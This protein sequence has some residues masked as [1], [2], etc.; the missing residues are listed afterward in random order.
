VSPRRTVAIT[1]VMNEDDDLISRLRAFGRRP[2][3]PGLAARRPSAMAAPALATTPATA[4]PDG[5]TST[6]AVPVA[7]P[8]LGS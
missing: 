4:P 3:D 6:T 7:V 5:T 2:V 8:G 1:T